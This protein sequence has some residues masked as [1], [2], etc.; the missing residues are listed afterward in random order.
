MRAS[1]FYLIKHSRNV[2][3][4]PFP[5]NESREFK[6]HKIP[7]IDAPPFFNHALNNISVCPA[8]IKKM[9]I[10]YAIMLERIFK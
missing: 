10:T 3:T 1:P 9:V 5:P 7:L 4:H 8:Q 6:K 2:K